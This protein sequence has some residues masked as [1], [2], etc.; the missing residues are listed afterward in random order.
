M[1]TFLLVPLYTTEGIL[2]SVAEY[3]KVNIIFSYFVL[4]N[5]IIAYGME[6]AFFR[7]FN[8]EKD[9]KAVIGTS[10]LSLLF[11][12][13]SFLFL[14][15]IFK[16]SISELT[17]IRSDYIQLVIWIL[18]LDALVI[19]PFARLRANEK[20]LRYAITKLINVAINLGLNLF[21]FLALPKLAETNTFFNTMYIENFGVNY[22][23]ISNLVASGITLLL[24]GDSYVNITYIFN[25]QLWKKMM[26]YAFPVLIAGVAFSINEAFD[27]ILLGVF[28]PEDVAEEKV[29]MYGACYRLAVFM[30][31]Y[32]T[33]F[34]LGIEPFFFSHAKTENPKEGYALITKYFAIF[35][36]IILLAVVVFVDVVKPLVLRSE[37]YWEAMVIVPIILLANLCLGI[38]HNLSVWYKITDRT[39]FGAY[40]STFGAFIT[41]LLN[42][43]L[44][45]VIGYL[46]S[47]LATLAAYGS[48]M[49]I[50]F[51]IG[52]K[53]YPIPYDVKK[54]AGY[55]LLSIGFSYL[56]FYVFE[57]NLW[58]GIIALLIFVGIVY[59]SERKT[60]KALLIN[61]E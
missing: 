30:T 52:Q 24:M 54:I 7:F 61:K 44:I 3:G 49:L 8:K 57:R 55:L 21:F 32:A 56:S 34:R 47:A 13:I 59:F 42:Y 36:S 25:T 2:S 26:R 50:S 40:I 28:L 10:M 41:L 1:L 48:M 22:I 11:S 17:Q 45:P 51:Y 53:K 46:G 4:F 5:V 23:F 60:L 12:S 19:I 6:T 33:A 43:L 29:G 38:Y 27:R 35:G 20:S 58:I 14:A 31:L 15:L 37:D 39:K 9:Q 16:G 18:F